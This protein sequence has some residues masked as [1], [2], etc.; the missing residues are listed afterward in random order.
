MVQADAAIASVSGP[1]PVQ[2]LV[3]DVVGLP[4][5]QAEA[6]IV[7]A[8]L[9]VGAITSQS[10]ATVPAGEV[11]SQN[12]VNPTLVDTGSA[13]D[14]VVSTGPPASSTS[15]DIRVSA[16]SDDAEE[17]SGGGVNLNSSDLELV[18]EG[19]LQTVGM[20]FNGVNIPQGTTITKAYVQFQVDEAN[21]E[22]TNLIIQG[23]KSLS[24]PTFINSNGNITSR[25]LTTASVGW[26]PSE[27]P[28]VGVAGPDQQTSDI[29]SIVQEI[30]N[31]GGWISGNSL[32][33]F[34]TGNGKR[35]AESF[36]GDAEWSRFVA[37]GILL[38]TLIIATPG[39][40][41][42]CCWIDPDSC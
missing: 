20:R 42:Q 36:N 34:I 28:T 25:P 1:A 4:Q 9:A 8:T 41:S 15:I 17:S 40:S 24:A 22:A 7:A 39:G 37:C 26:S 11:I 27:W 2:V 19:S 18:Q 6:A 30:V 13:V 16:N 38:R 29:K 33:I 10:S 3:P 21:T 23:E 14:I 31:Q 5:S 32:V 35:V 12:P